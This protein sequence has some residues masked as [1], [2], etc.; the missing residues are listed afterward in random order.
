V[1]NQIDLNRLRET[2]NRYESPS[3]SAPRFPQQQR[4]H[5][6]HGTSGTKRLLVVVLVFG[7]ILAIGWSALSRMT[8]DANPASIARSMTPE[9]Q[10]EYC[11]AAS[12]GTE[13]GYQLCMD[14]MYLAERGIQN[15]VIP[16]LAQP[17][18][19]ADYLPG[20]DIQMRTTF[21]QAM[22]MDGMPGFGA[23]VFDM[24]A[25]TI[26]Y[27]RFQE[28]QIAI[29][30]GADP[31]SFPDVN[32]VFQD[33]ERG[34]FFSL[35]NR[36]SIQP[37]EAS[38]NGSES[39][40]A[41]GVSDAYDDPA[42]EDLDDT[43]TPR[44]NAETLAGRVAADRAGVEVILD[45]WVPILSQKWVGLEVDGFLYDEDLILELDEELRNSYGTLMLWSG[46]YSSFPRSD[47]W[48][49]IIPS[50]FTTK[51]GALDWCRSSDRGRADCGAKFVSKTRPS[52]GSTAWLP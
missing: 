6:T 39:E 22:S 37:A 42:T 36:Q 3:E 32:L 33:C 35:Q 13:G 38:G 16:D 7:G 46:D 25:S 51:E 31:T 17:A 43:S 34:T 27:S 10:A 45:T 2:L 19:W 1:N 52:K 28:Q 5:V 24:I 20:Y 29:K 30:L 48:A 47:I 50:S 8:I 21:V 12:G 14:G 18:E 11:S 26:P 49:H 23:C 41:A 4:I 44:T 9:Q 40:A 15:P